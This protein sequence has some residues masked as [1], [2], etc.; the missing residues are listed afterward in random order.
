MRTQSMP[1]P[2]HEHRSR[3]PALAAYLLGTVDFDACLALQQRLVYEAGGRQDGQITL[4]ICEHS[5]AITMGRQGSRLDI[6]LSP[7]TL[8]SEGLTRALGQSGRRLAGARP[9]A[10]GDLSDCAA[11]ACM[12]G[13]VGDYL[14]RLQAGHCDGAGRD[15]LSWASSPTD[16]GASGAARDKSCRSAWP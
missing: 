7:R 12:V 8:A 14:D 10:I 13:R 6:R 15:R 11:G 4:L 3:R 5:P 16:A 2:K 1:L 9:R